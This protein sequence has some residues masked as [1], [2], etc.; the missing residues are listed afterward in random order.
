MTKHPTPALNDYYGYASQQVSVS[1]RYLF[2][3]SD[4]MSLHSI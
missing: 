3:V 4:G 2:T 1:E